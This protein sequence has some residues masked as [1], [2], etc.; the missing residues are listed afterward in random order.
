MTEKYID[1]V[2][3]TASDK[4][5][6]DTPF[7]ILGGYVSA[8]NWVRAKMLVLDELEQERTVGFVRV[9]AKSIV[10]AL[11]RSPALIESAGVLRERAE[12]LA[13]LSVHGNSDP[14][15]R[16]L[17][18]ASGAT[19]TGTRQ[20]LARLTGLRYDRIRDLLTGR[21]RYAS[22]WS[23]SADEARKGPGTPGRPRKPAP[24]PAM[25]APEPEFF[26][27]DETSFF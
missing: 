2:M 16:T 17:H 4:R 1:F 10:R 21:R 11:R 15:P 12:H 7:K 22:G 13:G 24:P 25:E 19:A 27:A 5:T 26:Q 14:R 9:Y 8:E 23:V 6:E 20:D 3:Q 18:H